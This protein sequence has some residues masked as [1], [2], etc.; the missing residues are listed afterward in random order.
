MLSFFVLWE[1]FWHLLELLG[2]F[3][4]PIQLAWGASHAKYRAGRASAP[5]YLIKNAERAAK[6]RSAANCGR[7]T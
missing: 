2:V 1:A 4:R 6:F 7:L 5:K 3:S